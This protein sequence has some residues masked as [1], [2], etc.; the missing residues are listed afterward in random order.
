MQNSQ[1]M[2]ELLKDGSF[3][4]MPQVV[5]TVS[6]TVISASRREVKIDIGGLLIGVV[7]GRELFAESSLYSTLKVGDTIEATVIEL[8]N[9]NG[10]ME[11]SFKYAG[12]AKAW[13]HM[14]SLFTSGETI[15]AKVLDA[16]K[17]GLLVKVEHVTGFL[18]VSQ[19]APEH[20]PRVSGG[21]KTRILEKLKE[22]VGCNF[23]VKVLDANEQD[24]KLIVSEKAVW[25]D[26]QKNVIAQYKVGDSVEGTVTAIADFGAFVKFPHA[27]R[28][29]VS[30]RPVHISIAWQR[31]DHPCD[32]LK[33]GDIVKSKIID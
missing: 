6:G 26:E 17:G 4:S 11:L 31:I 25:E 15:D 13:T 24:G 33:V 5:D 29:I 20:Y 27:R 14:K 8:E 21:A 1:Q 3:L 30:G 9:E 28:N 19:L 23:K 16:N 10:E 32:Y 18:P 7:R 2:E 22:Y 12:E